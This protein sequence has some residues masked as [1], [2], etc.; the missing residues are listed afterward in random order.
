M[1]CSAI[2]LNAAITATTKNVIIHFTG[3]AP[4]ETKMS[5]GGRERVSLVGNVRKSSQM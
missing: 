5:D 4:N 1:S 3:E 2:Q